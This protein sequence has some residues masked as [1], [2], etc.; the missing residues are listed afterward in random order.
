MPTPAHQQ[1]RQRACLAIV[2]TLLLAGGI[3]LLMLPMKLPL[4][5][6]VLLAAGDITVAMVLFTLLKQNRGRS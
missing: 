5:V 2:I 1:A 4:M 3:A 6:R